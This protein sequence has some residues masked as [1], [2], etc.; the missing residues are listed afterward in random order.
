L[1]E[2][3][4]RSLAGLTPHGQKGP[5]LYCGRT[6]LMDRQGRDYGFSPWL[7]QREFSF[8]NALL[9]NVGGGNTMVFNCPARALL[10][11]PL[12]LVS[13]DWWAYQM[14]VGC[15]G[16]LVYDPKPLL[17]YRQHVKN[18]VGHN[19]GWPN[20][21]NRLKKVWTGDWRRIIDRQLEALRKAAGNLT[22]EHRRCLERLV[23]LRRRKD[24]FQRLRRFLKGG[25]YRQS[26]LEQAAACLAVFFN[27]I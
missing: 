16:R 20:R 10:Q 11:Y 3:L 27:R 12:E 15:G 24:P 1:P 5:A 26:R 21:W 7:N 18:L 14:V 19:R 8:H 25:F 6:I 2:K 23:V 17:R 4:A 22:P 9:Q 13:H